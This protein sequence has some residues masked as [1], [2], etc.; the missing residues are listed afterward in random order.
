MIEV[1]VWLLITQN[2]GSNASTIVVER[3]KAG[4]QCEHVRQNLRWP[5]EA[6]CIQANIYIPAK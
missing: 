6:K 5:G 4:Q 1:L 3:F 2:S